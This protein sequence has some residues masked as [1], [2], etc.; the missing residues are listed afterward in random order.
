M[1]KTFSQFARSYTWGN[2]ISPQNIFKLDETGISTVQ[3]PR[4]IFAQ[5]GTKQVARI[6]S[7]ERGE[8]ATMC[9]CV[10][11]TGNAFPPASVFP[12]VHFKAHMLKGAATGSLGLSCSAGV[13]E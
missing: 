5:A 6:T 1:W 12:P 3:I 2:S 11:V 10:N 7:G 8:N 4:Q 9:A 13:D